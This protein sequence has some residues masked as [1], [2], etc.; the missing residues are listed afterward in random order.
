AIA[1]VSR[2][3]TTDTT[4]YSTEFN[5]QRRNDDADSTAVRLS[6]VTSS[7]SCRGIVGALSGLTASTSTATNGTMVNTEASTSSNVSHTFA[8]FRRGRCA[9]VGYV[10][11]GVCA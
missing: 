5:V 1:A 8:R 7:G 4:E 9:W 11:G 3:M 6:R 2:M 10:R